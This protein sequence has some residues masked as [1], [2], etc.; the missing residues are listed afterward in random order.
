[1]PVQI[2]RAYDHRQT[3]PG[4]RYLIDRLWPRGVPSSSLRLDGWLR[5]LAP[6][7]ELRHWFGH[8]P[9]KYRE[10]RDRYRQELGRHSDL[11]DR[12]VGEAQRG[13][14]TLVFGAKDTTHCNASVLKELLEERLRS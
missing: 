11:I 2:E 14:V 10:F 3:T 1:M 4:K 6:S 12:L 7:P 8:D 9:T 13:V 5:D